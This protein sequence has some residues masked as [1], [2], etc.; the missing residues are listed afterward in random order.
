V[1][2]RAYAAQPDHQ[3]SLLE[4]AVLV[5][6][7]A[8]PGLEPERVV[9]QIDA[10]ASPLSHRPLYRLPARV[11]AR[12]L[13]DHLFVRSGFRGDTAHYYDPR[14]SFLDQ[15]LERR[16]GIPISLSLIYI[17][18][19]RRVGI[20]ANPVSF[21]GHFLVRLDSEESR[22]LVVDPFNGGQVLSDPQL[23]DRLKQSGSTERFDRSHIEAT[24][25]RQV[26]ARML[27][28]LRNIYA[29]RGE[30]SRLLLVVDRLVD[31][32][33][34]SADEL[35][36]RGFLFARLGAPEAAV[37]DLQRYLTRFPYSKD[38]ANVE[39]SLRQLLELTKR[40]PSLV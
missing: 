22:P 31:L 13:G 3:L 30:Q 28:N 14:N 2:F 17:E 5:A 29:L 10:L 38:S 16:L 37:N 15:V 40:S 19:A 32:L 34:D 23:T 1:D 11:Q 39:K 7:D 27:M 33:P 8:R 36:E 18:V 21:P 35:R 12:A 9:A 24:P 4:G 25:V 26:I 20:N 6:A